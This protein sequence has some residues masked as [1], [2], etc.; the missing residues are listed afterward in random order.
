MIGARR[1]SLALA[2]AA[3]IALAGCTGEPDEV[4]TET[5]TATPE[6]DATP[7]SPA[8]GTTL[9]LAPVEA[10]P[11]LPLELG[12]Q[13]VIRDDTGTTVAT[14]TI[15][16]IDRNPTCRPGRDSQ[17]PVNGEYIQVTLGA[18]VRDEWDVFTLGPLPITGAFLGARLNG[19]LPFDSSGTAANCLGEQVTYLQPGESWS[20]PLVVDAPTGATSI[21]VRPWQ[22]AEARWELQIPTEADGT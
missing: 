16:S 20:G 12:E 11:T 9:T 21:T 6:A 4:V 3:L 1:T 17:N 13:I 18:T 10:P 5:V 2:A 7:T 14:M 15:N 22:G 8:D 19:A